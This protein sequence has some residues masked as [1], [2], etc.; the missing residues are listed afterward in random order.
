MTK[1]Q[2]NISFVFIRNIFS[3]FM[4]HFM[5]KNYQTC[6][7]LKYLGSPEKLRVSR[8]EWEKENIFPNTY[9]I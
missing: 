2:S 9:R 7:V 1:F 5:I 6:L 4:M 3:Y 8:Q